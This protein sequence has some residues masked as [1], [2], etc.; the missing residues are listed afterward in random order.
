MTGEIIKFPIG[1]VV[2]DHR[3]GTLVALSEADAIEQALISNRRAISTLRRQQASLNLRYWAARK[4]ETP[5]ERRAIGERNMRRVSMWLAED[6]AITA[7]NVSDGGD[8]AA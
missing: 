1:R 5:E 6:D 3:V 7:A 4:R 2:R 8:S